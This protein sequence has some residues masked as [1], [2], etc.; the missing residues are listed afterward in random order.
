MEHPMGTVIIWTCLGF[1]MGS[2]PFS[3]LLGRIFLKK[4]IRDYGDG[5]PGGY[6]AWRAGGWKVGLP[7]TLLDILK[8]FL[9]V[10]FTRSLGHEGWDLLPVALAPIIGHAWSPLLNFHGGKAI[11]TSL[12]VWLA[13]AGWSGIVAFAIFTLLMLAIQ[14]EHAWTIIVGMGGLTGYLLFTRHPMPL[15][16]IAAANLGIFVYKHRREIMKPIQVRDWLKH[17]VERREA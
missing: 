13:L 4:D 9:P 15:F 1:V 11:A 5:N 2:I 17:I 12:G 7:A 3:Y 14:V 6:N 8:G 10:F 16:W